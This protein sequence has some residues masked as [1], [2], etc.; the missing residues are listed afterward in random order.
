LR[1]PLELSA[2]IGS[3]TLPNPVM[4]A[5]GTAGHGCELAAY[6][7][8]G[9][10]GATVVKSLS[11]APWPGSP[12]T[13]VV[14][15][16]AGMINNVG[17]EGPGV[18]E[19]LERDLPPLLATGARVVVSVWGRTAGDFAKA[20]EMLADAPE[21]VVAVEVNAS[22]PNLDDRRRMFSHSAA[23]T[24]EV[25][26]ACG[27][28]GRPRWAKLSPNASDICEIAGAAL[29][30][31]AEALTLVNTLLALALDIEGRRPRL[32]GGLSGP[33][34]HPVA[35]RAVWDCRAAFPDAGIV[36]VGGVATG[37]AAVEMMM[38][39]ADA[40]QV[41]TASFADPRAARRVLDELA[42]W[43]R[44]HRVARVS[45]LVGACHG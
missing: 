42:R 21:Q 14:E 7:D 26:E 6:L 30:A 40:V 33:P 17:L 25:V 36:G 23:A 39:G 31:G 44:R 45:E 10:L 24:A 12:G 32:L 3:V 8:L 13:R 43:C 41:G 38:A 37:A 19:W 35:L 9:S 1:A 34:L 27:A 18:E 11:A 15:E 29:G 28:A 5:S 16:G 22:C 2:R 4:T 20:A